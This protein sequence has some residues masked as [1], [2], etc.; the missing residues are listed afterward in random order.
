[1]KR[2]SSLML[3]VSYKIKHDEGV[4]FSCYNWRQKYF[5]CITKHNSHGD[6]A[7]VKNYNVGWLKLIDFFR[8]YLIGIFLVLV[9]NVSYIA[10]NY[11]VK[12]YSLSAS[13]V[14]L[15]R[16]CQQVLVFSVILVYKN[17]RSQNEVTEDSKSRSY[18]KKLFLILLHGFFTATLSFSCVFAVSLMPISDLIVL[19]FSSPIFS[20]FLEAFFLKRQLTLVSVFLVFL[21]GNYHS[22]LI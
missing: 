16:G 1:M 19:G 21:I 6:T 8:N 11:I 9:S 13:E 15:V 18:I 10:N 12:I 22:S 4:V 17:C 14:S 3:K 2:F 5:I 20:V 7:K